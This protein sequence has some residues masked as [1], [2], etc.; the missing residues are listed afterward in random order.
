MLLQA[1]IILSF[2]IKSFRRFGSAE[3]ATKEFICTFVKMTE[4][5]G[6]NTLTWAITSDEPILEVSG[7]IIAA[8]VSNLSSALVSLKSVRV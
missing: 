6:R 5:D 8:V 2:S 1:F 3:V 4:R 7:G